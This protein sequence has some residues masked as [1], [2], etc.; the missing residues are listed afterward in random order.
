[1]GC[2]I[3]TSGTLPEHTLHS[4]HLPLCID[5]NVGCVLGM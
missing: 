3:V 5:F 2:I 4:D 1:V